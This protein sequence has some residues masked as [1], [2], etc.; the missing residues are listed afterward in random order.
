MA[1]SR[2][3]PPGFRPL[4]LGYNGANN[5]GA[6]VRVI[7]ILRQFKHIFGHVSFEPVLMAAGGQFGDARLES[8]Q[9]LESAAY[10]PDF[11]AQSA[12]FYTGVIACE[13]SMFTSTFSDSLTGMF[14][15]GMGHAAA[16]GHLSI[17]YGAEAAAMT[18]PVEN[19]VASA[20]RQSLIFARNGDSLGKL[21]KLGLR[22][23]AGADPAWSFEPDQRTDLALLRQAGWN[24]KDR[25]AVLCPIN[26][27]CW[28]LTVDMERARAAM[29][30]GSYEEQQ[31]DAISF[32]TWSDQA[33]R[34]YA[35]YLSGFAELARWLR[36]ARY[37]PV[38][39]GMQDLDRAS[40]LEL[41]AL[42][43]QPLP[44]FVRGRNSI[45]DIA[46]LLQRASLIVSS[47][48]HATV[49]GMSAGTPCIGVSMDSRIDSL[50]AENG[51]GEWL[52]PCDAAY[53]GALLVERA[54]R[55]GS[56][57]ELLADQY[58][59]LSARQIRAFGQMGLEL[60]AETAATYADF[61]A[62][63]LPGCWDAYLPPLSERV[64]KILCRYSADF[65]AGA[66]P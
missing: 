51:L 26:P 55:I 53:L 28:P 31:H 11:L 44:L 19:F 32:H 29:A 5:T 39:V 14:A 22:A 12:D 52:L 62:S 18:A 40:C 45:D 30:R 37:F 35:F 46:C 57:A 33:A 1:G 65:H 56:T 34:K 6:D 58:G 23:Q 61:P 13:G 42:L 21:Q 20:C 25:V 60:M 64:E 36:Q 10:F 4:L 7:E 16:L 15:G 8:V 48:Y 63:P 38:L 41:N 9:K 59:Q 2:A 17:G 49:I 66:N 47:R 54:S 27:F 43:D 3:R 24:G 50:F